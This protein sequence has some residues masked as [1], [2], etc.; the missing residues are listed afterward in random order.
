MKFFA[1]AALVAAVSGIKVKQHTPSRLQAVLMKHTAKKQGAKIAAQLLA[2]KDDKCPTEAE[3]KEIEAW[4]HHVLEDGKIT[5][6]EAM[7][8]Y[9]AMTG[10]DYD[11]LP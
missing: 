4:F 6:Q 11:N 9:K 3:K 7:D 2:L 10:E 5:P 8:G 1:L